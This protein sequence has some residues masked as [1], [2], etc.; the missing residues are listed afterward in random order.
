MDGLELMEG[1]DISTV[2]Q[3][4]LE[5]EAEIRKIQYWEREK[6]R[7][8]EFYEGQIKAVKEK[9]Q[10]HI[11]YHKHL[12]RNYFNSVPHNSTKT[13]ESYPLPSGKLVMSR[14]GEKLV[15]PEKD[16]EQRFLR[17]LKEQGITEYT[18][19][20]E[21][22]DWANYKKRLVIANGKAVDIETGEV[23]SI[24]V[25]YEEPKF[26]IKLNVKGEKDNGEENQVA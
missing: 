6:E 14:G 2:L 22:L 26:D 3:D 19:V 17:V 24:Q 5:A 15:R 20:K 21:A 11:D 23:V 1:Q 10:S 7:M 13:Q 9:C 12:L 16:E 4:D 25:D 8:T 18:K